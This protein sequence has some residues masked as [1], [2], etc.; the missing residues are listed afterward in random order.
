MASRLPGRSEATNKNRRPTEVQEAPF[1][2]PKTKRVFFAFLLFVVFTPRVCWATPKC[3][4]NSFS[5][6]SSQVKTYYIFMSENSL[7]LLGIYGHPQGILVL[8][9]QEFWSF[10][11]LSLC[12]GIPAM[13][14]CNCVAGRFTPVIAW[15]LLRGRPRAQICV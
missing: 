6:W 3:S 12:N 14:I 5:L 7:G 1:Q 4:G 8:P 10:H 11:V 2:F 9:R 15:P 13:A